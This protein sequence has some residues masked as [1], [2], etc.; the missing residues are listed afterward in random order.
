MVFDITLVQ[1]CTILVNPFLSRYEFGIP[2]KEL[3][4]YYVL[5]KGTILDPLLPLLKV[6]VN[7]PDPTSPYS[8]NVICTQTLRRNCS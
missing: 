3:C 5:T 1:F 6:E 2:L 4:I 8:A 7:K